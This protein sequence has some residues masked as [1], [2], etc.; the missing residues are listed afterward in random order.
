MHLKPNRAA[1][2]VTQPFNSGIVQIYRVSDEATPGY[3]PRPVRVLV[4]TLR[5]EERTLGLTRYYAAKEAQVEV[6]RVIRTPHRRGVSPQDI[7]VTEDGSAYRID[8]IQGVSS[9][10]PSMDLTLTRYDQ[11]WKEGS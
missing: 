9:F 8:L 4:E 1:H 10:P 3:R 6:Q 2:D 11:Q 5:Y 7:A